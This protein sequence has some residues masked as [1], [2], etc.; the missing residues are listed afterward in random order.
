[1]D[2]TRTKVSEVVDTNRLLFYSDD[3]VE[4]DDWSS[5]IFQKHV[6][7]NGDLGDRMEKAFTTAFSIS[8]KALIVGSDCPYI[9]ADII[10]N[11]FD[12]LEHHDIVIGPTFDGGYYMMGMKKLHLPLFRNMIW[13]TEQVYSETIERIDSME[14]SYYEG[15]R[16]SDIDYAEDWE[17][18]LNSIDS[19]RH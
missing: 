9:T 13:S 10:E 19:S 2:I 8:Q 11:A 12:Q 14:L 6:Q 5:S 1:L 17:A 15:L 4:S 3:I 18:Y 16:L 7:S